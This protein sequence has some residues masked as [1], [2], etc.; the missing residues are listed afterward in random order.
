MWTAIRRRTRQR[1]K[2]PLRFVLGAALVCWGLAVVVVLVRSFL[3]LPFALRLQQR[4]RMSRMWPSYIPYDCPSASGLSKKYRLFLY[5]EAYPGRHEGHQE[6]RGTPAIFIPG[7]AGSFGQVRS[8]ASSAHHLFKNGQG[9]DDAREIDWWTVDFNEDF[10]AFHGQTMH[11]QAEYI[12]EVLQYLLE[13]YP[14]TQQIPILAHSMGGIVARLMILKESHPPGSVDTIIT[15]STPHAYPPVPLD[16]GVEQVYSQINTR[17]EENAGDILLIS[18]SGGILDNQLSSE[19]A[20][21]PLARI[22]YS[23]SSISAFTSGLPALWSGV[24]H[25]AMMW[26]DQLRERIARGMLRIEGRGVGLAERREEW[27]RVLGIGFEQDGQPAPLSVE[28]ETMPDDSDSRLVTIYPVA[29]AGPYDD[30]FELIVD[31]RVGLDPSFGPPIEQDVQI[32]VDL[33][34]KSAEWGLSCRHVLPSAYDLYPPTPETKHSWGE[35]P[36]FP[37]AEERYEM[38]GHGLRRLHISLDQ[39]NEQYIDHIRVQK[40]RPSD[41]YLVAAGWTKQPRV[42]DDALSVTRSNFIPLTKTPGSTSPSRDTIAT[43]MDSSLLAYSIVFLATHPGNPTCQFNKAPLLRIESLSTGDIQYFPTIWSNLRLLVSFHATSPYMPPSVDT[44]RGTKFTLLLDPCSRISGILVKI[45]WKDSAGLLLSR[46]RSAIASLPIAALLLLM[47]VMWEE[48]D[49]TGQSCSMTRSVYSPFADLIIPCS[50]T[51]PFPSPTAAAVQYAPFLIPLLVS[52]SVL[53]SGLQRL[54]AIRSSPSSHGLLPSYLQNLTFGIASSPLL[55]SA[56]LGLVFLS[57]AYG[58]CLL[59]CVVLDMLIRFFAGFIRITGANVGFRT[60][61]NAR[62]DVIRRPRS[63]FI[64]FFLLALAVWLAV[65]V[66]FV[67]LV[68]FLIQFYCAVHSQVAA[69]SKGEGGDVSRANQQLLLLNLFFWLLPSNAPALLIWSRNL[70]RGYY[71]VLGGPD[72]NIFY[73]IG[74]LAVS[75]ISSSG[76]V[77]HRSRSR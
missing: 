25:L 68:L 17:W 69:Q 71:G 20:I 35:F 65:P 70:V 73:V 19:P 10:S 53:L 54:A 49:Q 12:N 63:T 5:R 8:V 36:E 42:V 38:P 57:S 52:F 43:S 59:V 37:E 7:N 55:A 41:S 18:L 62:D 61:D 46:Y 76:Y 11:D 6:P 28:T 4:C 21:L 58:L 72:H 13:Q 16:M 34:Q 27:R 26:C 31:L 24:D 50:P 44:R 29:D 33:C 66:Q 75:Q 3:N 9:G 51:A 67:F 1:S 45:N 60:I 64:S 2:G 39:L 48:W 15:L 30:A 77:L 40:K 47:S 32:R 56:F 74:F 22:W 23:N 14:M